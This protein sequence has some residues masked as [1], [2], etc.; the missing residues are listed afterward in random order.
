MN[1]YFGEDCLV[2]NSGIDKLI[3]E[4]GNNYLIDRPKADTFVCNLGYDTI[5]GFN[6]F[7]SDIK[8]SD[9]EV[10]KE[11]KNYDDMDFTFYS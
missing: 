11:G 5:I 7:E 9:C 3:S 6:S 8:I 4:I 10:V 1:S 2:V